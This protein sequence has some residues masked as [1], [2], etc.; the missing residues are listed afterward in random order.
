MIVKKVDAKT[1]AKTSINELLRTLTSMS[2]PLKSEPR[3]AKMRVA[4]ALAAEVLDYIAPHVVAGVTTSELESP[5]P[6]LHGRRAADDSRAAQLRAAGPP[7]YP[8]S[9][10]T[11]VNHVVCHG[12][13]GDKRLKAGDIVNIDVTVIKDGI[14]RRHEPH[15]LRRRSRRSRRSACAK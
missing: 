3:V 12:I 9:I 10:C 14:P 6:R 1:R 15:V 13:P 2:V 11:S 7:P 8:A 4:G 5:L